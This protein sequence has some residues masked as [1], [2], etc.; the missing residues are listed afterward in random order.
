MIF[1]GTSKSSVASM[2]VAGLMLAAPALAQPVAQPAPPPADLLPPAVAPAPT[3]T[4]VP[5]PPAPA[6]SRRDAQALLAAV[7]A[8]GAEGLDP[9]DY[10]PATL[11]AAIA[12][13]E[14]VALNETA[15]RLFAWLVEDL[16]DGRTPMSARVQWFVVDPD[17][18]LNPT[19]LVLARALE[20]HD[21][22][23]ELAALAP[24]HPD[25][26]ALRQEL[27]TSTGDKTVIRAN[28]DR[29]RWL[30]RDMGD[31]YLL[32]NVPEYMLRLT[33]KNKVIT[34]YRTVVGKPGKTATP[35]LAET[36]Q[37][38]IFNPTWTVPQ[39]I[40]KGEGLGAQ[41]L[42]NPARAKRENYKVWK[43]KA[44][45]FVTVVQQPGKGNSLGL[46]KL[47]MP[48]PHAIFVHDTPAKSL[49]A[50]PN[51]AFSH[52]CIRTERA[53][54]LGMLMAM[55]GGGL[56]KEEGVAHT[57]SGEYTKV[58]MTKTFPVYITYFTM[59][60]DVTGGM[61]KFADIYGRDAPVLTALKAP[62]QL[63]TDQRKSNEKVI[64]IVDDLGA[65]KT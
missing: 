54:E 44:T 24:L 32:T 31:Q 52:G 17:R 53:S 1:R 50:A 43:D 19:A 10:E 55:L 46:M 9:K 30:A 16:R 5:P 28:M 35:Q 23:G 29:W 38:V 4:P 47:D 62:R 63:H 7:Q 18:D 59:A 40:V 15:T 26:A 64:E 61:R 13:G 11:A 6:W 25:Y 3:P 41:L 51:R 48:N 36:V 8:I 56:T 37:G 27:A 65:V 20:K 49:F 12:A 45:G 39:S 2:A 42:A 33:V 57:L 21:V 60:R 14:G 22:A 34:S 58:P